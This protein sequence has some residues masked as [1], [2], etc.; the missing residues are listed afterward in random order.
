MYYATDLTGA[1][2]VTMATTSTG[3]TG[4]GQSHANLMPTLTV[5]YC[6]ATVGLFPTQ[7]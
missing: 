4:T 1:T 2:A 6:I 3:L 5:Q 7:S